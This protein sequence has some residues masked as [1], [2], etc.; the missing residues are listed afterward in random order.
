MKEQI[1]REPENKITKVFKKWKNEWT[2]EE[3]KELQTTREQKDALAGRPATPKQ[4]ERK[5][6][7]YRK[8]LQENGI[9]SYRTKQQENKSENERPK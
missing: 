3:N 2:S 6:N 9:K 8:K 5:I 7:N 4:Q 1:L